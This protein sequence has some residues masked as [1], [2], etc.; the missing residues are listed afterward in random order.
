MVP[1]HVR[2]TLEPAPQHVDAVALA[3]KVEQ[4]R[5]PALEVHAGALYGLDFTVEPRLVGLCVGESAQRALA[6]AGQIGAQLREVGADRQNRIEMRPQGGQLAACFGEIHDVSMRR[7]PTLGL[8]RIC[9]QTMVRIQLIMDVS[10]E[11]RSQ[12]RERR[13][14]T[15]SSTCTATTGRTGSSTRTSTYASAGRGRSRSSRRRR[16]VHRGAEADRR[17]PA[18][19]LAYDMALVLDGATQFRTRVRFAFSERDGGTRLQFTQT[20]LPDEKTRDDFGKNWAVV[21]DQLEERLSS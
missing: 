20:G 2:V 6:G 9:D 21:F 10:L 18:D 1:Q 13:F 16:P 17:R 4:Q 11:H 3:G 7:R 14:S 19:L 15:A 8:R 5:R 12:C